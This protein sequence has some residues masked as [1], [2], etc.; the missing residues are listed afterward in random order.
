MGK[1]KKRKLMDTEG[2]GFGEFARGMYDDSFRLKYDY[3][4]CEM[5]KKIKK[6]DAGIEYS[7][8]RIKAPLSTADKLRRKGREVTLE[9][10]EKYLNDIAGICIVYCYIDDVYEAARQLEEQEGLTLLKKKDFIKSPKATGYRSLHLIFEIEDETWCGVRV[11]VQI[12]TVSMD[13]WARLDHELRYKKEIPEAERLSD[14]LRECADMIAY[15]DDKMQKI[16]RKL[17][18]VWTARSTSPMNG[19]AAPA[20]Q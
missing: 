4:L 5:K 12:R 1:K 11:E 3:A 13:A 2:A 16:H 18:P 8:S 10:A 9:A 6:L 15:I 20:A 14:E 7:F 17:I 19:C